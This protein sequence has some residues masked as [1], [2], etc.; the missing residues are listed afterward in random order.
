MNTLATLLMMVQAFS[1]SISAT[2]NALIGFFGTTEEFRETY[3]IAPGTELQVENVNGDIKISQ[4]AENQ[5]AVYAKK[6]TNHGEEELSKVDIEVVVNGAM[7]I[8]TKYLEKGVHVSVS[9]VIRVP[10]EVIVRKVNTSNGE[11]EINGT[12]GDVE[13]L[14]SNGE[15][16]F[17]D[18][19]GTVSAKTSNGEIEIKGTTAIVEAITSNGEIHAE[20]LTLP[21]EG[22]EISTSNGSI[23]VY[24]VDDLNGD[25]MAATSR[26]RVQIEDVSLQSRVKVASRSSSVFVGEIGNGGRPLNLSTSNGEISLHRVSE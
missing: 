16:D 8:R 26:G 11:I 12:R 25:L 2:P 23:H 15:I 21:E 17:S 18:I 4:W 1:P 3:R 19:R 10:D 22:T 20:I 14:T 24:I 5:V 9:Y 7:R 13:A 6:K